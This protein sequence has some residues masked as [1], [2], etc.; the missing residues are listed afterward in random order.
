ML[1]PVIKEVI[2]MRFF[3]RFAL[4]IL[5]MVLLLL[6][7][8]GPEGRERTLLYYSLGINIIIV[9]AGLFLGK[10]EH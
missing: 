5:V 10:K 7:F 4:L 6:T 8:F 1:F 2:R 3:V 9:L